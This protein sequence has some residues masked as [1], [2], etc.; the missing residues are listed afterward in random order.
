[1]PKLEL[2]DLRVCN[3]QAQ[4]AFYRDVLGMVEKGD[5]SIGYAAEE[6]VLRFLDADA[7][8][9]PK[10][11]DLYWKIA[12]SVPN[13]ELACEQLRAKGVAVSDPVQFRDVGYLAKF[14]DPEG[15]VIELIDHWFKGERPDDHAESQL[16]ADRAHLSLLTLR[17][18]DIVPIQQACADWGMKPLSVQRVESHGFTLYFFAFTDETPPSPDLE[19][20]ENR[21]W[22]Y[23]RPYT[24]LEI[25][26]LHDLTDVSR[27]DASEAGYAGFRISG[28]PDVEDNDTGLMVFG[29]SKFGDD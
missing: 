26:H 1:M 24:V 7:P 10:P 29:G 25:Q 18:A 28:V 21:A 16:L 6:A 17:S 3:R 8:Y 2:I 23:R 13:I 27:P 22:T 20:I 15:F 4:I 9:A 14:T 12:L 19:A 11:D 5:D